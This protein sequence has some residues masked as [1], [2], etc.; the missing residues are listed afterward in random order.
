MTEED[1]RICINCIKSDEL[2]RYY[3]SSSLSIGECLICGEQQLSIDIEKDLKL[4][5]LLKALIR[6][7]YNEWQYNEIWGGYNLYHLFEGDN[8]ILNNKFR[9]PQ[10]LDV[11]VLALKEDSYVSSENGLPLYKGYDLS[12]GY[13][14][15]LQQES[16]IIISRFEERIKK[17]NQFKIEGDAL[18]LIKKLEKEITNYLD[19]SIDLYRARIGYEKKIFNYDIDYFDLV[20]TTNKEFFVP[21]T[22]DQIS[23]PP[24]PKTQ[25]ARLSRA[26]IS[27]VYLASEKNTAIAEIRPNPG[28]FVSIGKFKLTKRLKFADFRTISIMNFFE[29]EHD[30]ENFIFL[31]NINKKFSIPITP[32]KREEYLF[33]QFITEVIRQAGF[34]GVIFD[35]SVGDGYNVVVFDLENINYLEGTGQVFKVEGLKYEYTECRVENFPDNVTHTVL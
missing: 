32:E 28:H 35:S 18:L 24:P 29:S 31:N 22:K 12:S 16:S 14:S 6:Y 21:F 7:Y 19:Q 23:A 34:T 25:S 4:V 26:G 17:E 1:S 3:Q 27:Y 15:T 20:D 10:L 9:Y 5:A 13:F 33:T 8:P 11:I 30:I 2:K